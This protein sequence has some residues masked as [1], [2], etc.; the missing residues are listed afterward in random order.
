MLRHILEGVFMEG[1]IIRSENNFDRDEWSNAHGLS[2]W[3]PSRTV[4]DQKDEADINTIVRNFGVTGKVPQSVRVPE[5]GDFTG[6]S[7]YRTALEAIA[8]AEKS[9]LSMPADVRSKFDNDPQ[10]FLEYCSDPENIPEMRKLGL[11]VPEVVPEV[12]VEPPT[13]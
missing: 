1:L 7:D 2:D 11:A 4:Q 6:I 12:P 8:E 13:A 5:Y 10:L 9:F 3:G